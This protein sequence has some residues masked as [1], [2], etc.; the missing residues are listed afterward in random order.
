VEKNAKKSAAIVTV[1]QLVA[2][3]LPAE[4]LVSDEISP[5][6]QHALA[7]VLASSQCTL[8]SRR[9]FFLVSS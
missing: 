2:V 7:V 8:I 6:A 9:S 1:I 4:H 5:S 3:H